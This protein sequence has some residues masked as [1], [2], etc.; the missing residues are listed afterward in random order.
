MVAVNP[1]RVGK[2]FTER[3]LRNPVEIIVTTTNA[4]LEIVNFNVEGEHTDIVLTAGYLHALGAILNYIAK[5]PNGAAISRRVAEN[6]QSKDSLGIVSRS[7][8]EA[9]Q[10]ASPITLQRGTA[11]IPLQGI[12]VPFHLAHLRAGVPSYRSFLKD[13]NPER[14]IR[15]WIP[16]IMGKTFSLSPEYIQDAHRLTASP[17]LGEVLAA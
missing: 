2:F 14:L 15:K 12:D 16:N 3:A 4:L 11:T 5:A 13:V 6:P 9:Q 7:V 10:L 17:I 8:S 1:A